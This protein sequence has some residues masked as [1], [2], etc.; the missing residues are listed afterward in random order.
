MIYYLDNNIW[1]QT[2]TQNVIRFIFAL[3]SKHSMS[4]SIGKR[5]SK[6]DLILISMHSACTCKTKERMR[7]TVSEI[8]RKEPWQLTRLGREV[9]VRAR[10]PRQAPGIC[11]SKRHTLYAAQLWDGFT[12]F[13][14]GHD[15][16]VGLAAEKTVWQPPADTHL[17]DTPGPTEGLCLFPQ[18]WEKFANMIWWKRAESSWR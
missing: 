12:I 2:F 17:G 8:N 16:S 10:C 7:E 9:P 3:V 13:L 6:S 5:S 11:Y 15:I 18:N 1:S 14:T 4:D